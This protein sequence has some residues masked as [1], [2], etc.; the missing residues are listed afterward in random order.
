MS[1]FSVPIVSIKEV[2]KHPNADN[3]EILTFNEIGW[4]CVDKPGRKPNDLVVYIPIDSVVNTSRP[5]FQFLAGKAKFDGTFRIRTIRL[6]GEISQG[7]VIDAPKELDYDGGIIGVNPVDAIPGADAAFHFGITKY[8]PP[9]EHTPGTAAGSFPSWCEK[10]DAERYQNYNRNIAP[11][12]EEEFYIS[13]KMDGTSCTIFYDADRSVTDPISNEPLGPVGVC[14]RNW[15]VREYNLGADKYFESSLTPQST[16]S[17]W[18]TAR[19]HGLLDKV[20]EISVLL[21]SPKVAIQGEICGPGIQKNKYG[22]TELSFFAFDIYDGLKGDFLPYEEFLGTCERFGIPT[23]PQID[24]RR[25]AGDIL[26]NFKWVSGLTYPPGGP[27]EGVVYVAKNPRRVGN[28]GRLK[29]KYIN[30]EFLLKYESR[31]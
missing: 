2:V 16:N 31:D 11:F 14:S 8:E 1:N 18:R 20:R 15:E 21:G 12:E 3:L 17:Y 13:L 26:T 29:F 6:R 10:S 27:A 22:L 23:V 19:H 5:E 7:L 24:L 25:I 30:P 4:T 9:A 28:L